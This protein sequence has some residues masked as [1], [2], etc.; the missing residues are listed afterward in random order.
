LT[1]NY[2]GRL[3]IQPGEEYKIGDI[4]KVV[5]DGIG[6]SRQGNTFIKLQ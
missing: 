1:K 3:I 2:S 5:F 6:I 4:V